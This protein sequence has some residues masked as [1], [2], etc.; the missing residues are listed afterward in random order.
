L[1]AG[2]PVADR[3]ASLNPADGLAAGA[4]T[5]QTSGG[6]Q[7]LVNAEIGEGGLGI[8]SAPQPGSLNIRASRN[9]E[10]VTAT[11]ARF[12]NE[13]AGAEYAPDLRARYSA[14]ELAGRKRGDRP[15]ADKLR[16]KP[17]TK[18]EEA[19]E[20]GLEFL[21]RIQLPDGSWSFT[22]FKQ[23]YEGAGRGSINSD[24]AATGLVLMAFLGAGYDHFD[25]RYETVV[26]KGLDYLLTNQKESGELYVARDKFANETT[27]FYSHGIASIALCEAYGLTSDTKLREPAQRALDFLIREQAK[28]RGGWR[29]SRVSDRKEKYPKED[30]KKRDARAESDISVTGWAMMALKSGKISQLK[31]PDEAFERIEVFLSKAQVSPQDGSQYIYNPFSLERRGTNPTVTSVGLLMRR[32]LGWNRKNKDLVRGAD[33]L[34]AN[35][36]A[37]GTPDNPKRDTYYWYYATQVMRHMEGEHW[38]TWKERLMPML[39]ESQ[40][41][42]GKFAGSWSPTSPVPDKWAR[43]GGRIYVTAMNLLSLEVD[44]R[45][46][47]IHDVEE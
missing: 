7:V 37:V 29:Y 8:E 42:E 1:A 34:M 38:R 12:Q 5:R 14:P 40:I 31:V 43:H 3:P 35:L 44:Y 10:V 33:Y 15:G 41:T 32:Y 9:S 26:R 45:L 27:R 2:G 36:P 20:Y 17:A 13:K 4:E 18:T 21:A 28:P 30:D 24:T 22:N 46:I 47:K 23:G 6:V 19:I 39:R 11:M 16:G 25:A